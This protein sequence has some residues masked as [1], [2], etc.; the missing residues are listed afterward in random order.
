MNR[1][2]V[3]VSVLQVNSKKYYMTGEVNRPGQYPLIT[4]TSILQ[5][6][7]AAGGLREFAS[8]KKIVIVRGDLRLKFNYKEVVDGK[9]LK[10]N[11]LLE[12][13][14]HVIVP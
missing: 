13:G 8:Q 6:I 9:N 3:F 2:E 11:V 12:S 14:D 7:S 1:A 5:A 4:Q 10:Q